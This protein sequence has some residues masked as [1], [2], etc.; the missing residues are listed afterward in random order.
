MGWANESARLTPPR[1]VGTIRAMSEW[2]L[3]VVEDWRNWATIFTDVDLWRPVI[4]HV[5][6]R[7]DQLQGASGVAFPTRI[8]A[9]YPGTC[10]V[11]IVDKTAVIKF[12]PPMVAGDFDREVAVYRLIQ[13]RVPNIPSLLSNG[14]HQDYIAWPYLAVSFLPGVAWRDVYQ[15]L[16]P[17]QSPALMAQL[18]RTVRALHEIPLPH[19]GT[20]PAVGAWETLVSSRIS[21][22]GA[23]L[24]RS[25]V[26]PDLV[27]AQIELELSRM[28]WYGEKICLLHSDL[29]E[30]HLLVAGS[31]G[32]WSIT[33]LI[34][35]ADAEVGPPMY[36]WVA[37]WF[38]IC[39]REPALFRAFLQGYGAAEEVYVSQLASMTFLHRYGANII[40]DTL[41]PEEQRAMASLKELNHILFSGLVFANQM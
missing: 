35:W 21:Q 18:G 23:E 36:D 41:A 33:G 40:A 12:F 20:W 7:D 4:E 17:D 10:A 25:T 11:F 38:S 37:L 13:G 34:D 29:T 9:G 31:D 1:M 32:H 5:W 24:R 26:L 30:D 2:L 8:D 27:I 16:P 22:A 6:R 28:H 19:S 14:W 39:H 3:P 15:R